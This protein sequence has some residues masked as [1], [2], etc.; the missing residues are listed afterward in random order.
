MKCEDCGEEIV[1]VTETHRKA[2]VAGKINDNWV[3]VGCTSL[4]CGCYEW[5]GD[6]DCPYHIVDGRVVRKPKPPPVPPGPFDDLTK[7]HVQPF[8]DNI[9]N[10]HPVLDQLRE[11]QTGGSEDGRNG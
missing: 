2:S 4:R 1:I 5:E 7:A 11:R 8:V 9:F 10:G 3:E 6:E